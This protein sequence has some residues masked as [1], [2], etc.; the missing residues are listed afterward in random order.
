MLSVKQIKMLLV[1]Y[2]NTGNS[3]PWQKKK[4]FDAAATVADDEDVWK[5]KEKD[6]SKSSILHIDDCSF[7]AVKYTAVWSY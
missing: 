5:K 1:F 3:L 2:L 6:E 4:F 7:I